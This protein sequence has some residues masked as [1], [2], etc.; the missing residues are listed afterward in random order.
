MPS[1]YY[2]EACVLSSLKRAWQ[3]VYENGIKSKSKQ[4]QSEVR[5]F[6]NEADRNL[7][8]IYRKLLHK[9]W[10]FE[11]AFGV[12]KSRPGKKPRPIVV[13]P[14]ANRIIQ[15]SILDVLQKVPAIK[16]YY[17]IESSFGGIEGKSVRNAIEKIHLSIKNGACYYIRSDIKNFFSYIPKDKVLSIIASNISDPDFNINSKGN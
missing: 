8:R 14:I 11:P 10:E 5:S 7:G 4:T 3:K 12:L 2:K 13:S 16:T 6:A 17:D 15:R 9:K 1:N